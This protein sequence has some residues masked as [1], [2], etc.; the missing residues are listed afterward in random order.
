MLSDS[1]SLS[2]YIRYPFV[3]DAIVLIFI[4]SKVKEHHAAAAGA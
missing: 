2:F 4:V 3:M 1:S